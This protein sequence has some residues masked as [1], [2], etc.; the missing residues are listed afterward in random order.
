MGRSFLSFL[1]FLVFAGAAQGQWRAPTPQEQAL[2][3]AAFGGLADAL[4]QQYTDIQGVVLAVGGRVVFSW[5]RD[6][7]PDTLRD[8]QSVNKS[9]LSALVGIAIGEGRIAGIDQPVLAL[10][11]EWRGLNADP[12][13]AAITVRHLLTLSAGFAVDDATGTGAPGQPAEAW[14]RPLR[15]APGAQFV[16]DNGSIALLRAVLEKATG[17]PLPDYAR[18]RLVQPLG[19]AEP[20]YRRAGRMRTEDMARLGEL[21]LRRGAWD[22]RQLLPA[23]YVDEATR[24]QSDGGPPVR[25]PYGLMW[26]IP[27]AEGD[28]RTFMANGFGGQFIWA[29][30]PRGTVA[31]VHSTVAPASNERGHAIQFILRQVAPAVRQRLQ[32]EAR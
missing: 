30:P 26:W 15:H 14:A 4:R 10:V 3:A 32:D 28:R 29:W 5:H 17:M 6:G 18:T 22:G 8:I 31:A 23:E 13:A 9:V 25:M 21:F 2:D 12:R 7:A 16:Y 24:A 19:M 1:S 11:P 27:G 20:D